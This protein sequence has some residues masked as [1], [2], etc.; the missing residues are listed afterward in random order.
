MHVGILGINYKSSEIELREMLARVAIGL[1]GNESQVAA[2]FS[3]VLLSTCNRT[4]IYF[5]AGQ[6]VEAHSELLNL[7]R[8]EL[9]FPF[10]HKLYA[11]FGSECFAHL[12]RVTA[13][14]DS[15]IVAE[16]EIQRQVKSAY[17]HAALDHSLSRDMHFLFQKCLKVGKNIRSF[18]SFPK[19]MPTLEKLIYELCHNLLDSFAVFFIGNSEINRKILTYFKAKGLKDIT[20]CTRGL[21]SAKALAERYA[22]KLVDWT[23]KES[24]Q[25]AEVVICGSNYND[26]LIESEQITTRCKNKI[27]FDLGLPRNVDP[28][29]ARHPEICL[30]NIEELENLI[31]TERS[32]QMQGIQIAEERLR[33]QMEEQMALFIRHSP[34]ANTRPL[35]A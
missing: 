17:S 8:E 23:E 22:L 2:R 5:S 33:K 29:L 12:S 19:G 27:I 6:L 26:Y 18:Y 3:I 14:L 32:M 24:W 1:F 9:S 16:T 13:G 25:L 15:A 21:Y 10:E 4:E 30:F 20:L 28:R 7:L 34:Y 31:A 35:F 11:Y